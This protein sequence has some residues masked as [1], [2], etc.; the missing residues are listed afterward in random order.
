MALTVSD[1]SF[2]GSLEG[3]D[4]NESERS[5]SYAMYLTVGDGGYGVSTAM[6]GTIDPGEDADTEDEGQVSNASFR[7]EQEIEKEA[8]VNT[9][10]RPCKETSEK[11]SEGNPLQLPDTSDAQTFVSSMPCTDTTNVL[12]SGGVVDDTHLSDSGDNSSDTENYSLNSDDNE[13]TND[14][15]LDDDFDGHSADD[16]QVNPDGCIKNLSV[17]IK[18]EPESPVD[19]DSST[20]DQSVNTTSP[21][22]DVHSDFSPSKAFSLR[23]NLFQNKPVNERQNIDFQ[24]LDNVIAAAVSKTYNK[25]TD[26]NGS[27]P[28]QSKQTPKVTDAIP[29]KAKPVEETRSGVVVVDVPIH[30]EGK[31]FHSCSICHKMFKT[32]KELRVHSRV[33]TKEKPYACY[34]CGKAFRQ[35][36]HLNSHYKIHSGEKP[37]SCNLCSLS[38]TENSSLKRHIRIHLGIKPYKCDICDDAFVTSY[39]LK[40]HKTRRHEEKQNRAT[41]TCDR[42]PKVYTSKE[43][44]NKHLR[45]HDP[46]TRISCSYCGQVCLT[47]SHLKRHINVHTRTDLCNLQTKDKPFECGICQKKYFN[48]KHLELHVVRHTQTEY[49]S[50]DTCDKAF[51]TRYKWKRHVRRSH[52]EKNGER[53]NEPKLFRCLLCSKVFRTNENLE[54]HI[55]RVHD[56]PMIYNCDL[57][58]R[59]F[60]RRDA[61]LNHKESHLGQTFQCSLCDRNYSTSM[62]LKSHMRKKHGKKEGR[63]PTGKT[64]SEIICDFCHR[65]FCNKASLKE[66]VRTRHSD[67][68]QLFTCSLCQMKF[69][70]RNSLQRHMKKSCRMLSPDQQNPDM[71]HESSDN[72]ASTS[73]DMTNH[74]VDMD[75]DPDLAARGTDMDMSLSTDIMSPSAEDSDDDGGSDTNVEQDY[76][77]SQQE[78]IDTTCP[79]PDSRTLVSKITCNNDQHQEDQLSCD[80]HVTEGKPIFSTIHSA[81]IQQQEN[82]S[83]TTV[84]H[85]NIQQVNQNDSG[86]ELPQRGKASDCLSESPHSSPS[87][88]KHPDVPN[89][90]EPGINDGNSSP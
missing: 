54:S 60:L 59:T 7:K 66:H 63:R 32:P 40:T 13:P 39:L 45:S 71:A 64:V 5:E 53:T 82:I 51:D 52:F 61:M 35:Q 68:I 29:K 87:Q 37:Y 85:G 6:L 30:I 14:M 12:P 4:S 81:N 8:N 55:K 42:C 23:L 26:V 88:D 78:D 62:T 84:H 57:C 46:D 15:E 56:K 86:P 70:R 17:A 19:S 9:S 47:S 77:Y 75:A 31:L 24:T 76:V 27:E 18:T 43:T 38:F 2:T 44:F 11:S 50:C 72:D 10:N 80:E 25:E 41:F 33:H 1:N 3:S 16:Q 79:Q 34:V 74:S 67:N 58:E 90:P 49:F 21:G 69:T 65:A 73:P 48:K 20:E 89:S 22:K 28:T 83:S 36:A